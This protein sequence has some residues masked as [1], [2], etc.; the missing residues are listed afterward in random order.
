VFKCFNRKCVRSVLFISSRSWRQT[1]FKNNDIGPS[2]IKIS[3]RLST[4]PSSSLKSFLSLYFVSLGTMKISTIILLLA[5]LALSSPSVV[6]RQ[7]KGKL[8][9]G[10]GGGGQVCFVWARGSLEPSPLVCCLCFTGTI[11]IDF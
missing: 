8:G 3:F 7:G 6:R 4:V 9:G 1:N 2:Y 10:G 5:P 11:W